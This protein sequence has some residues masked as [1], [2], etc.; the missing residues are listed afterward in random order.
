MDEHERGLITGATAT[1]IADSIERAV[2]QARL[3]PGD[4]LP[5]I[6][7]L[8][9]RLGV[10]PTTV[11]AA[12][13]RL[14]ARGLVTAR[15]RGGTAVA[16]RPPLPVGEPPA[17]LPP[18]VRDLTHG[19]ADPALLSEWQVYRMFDARRGVWATFQYLVRNR[20]LEAGDQVAVDGTVVASGRRR[21]RRA[22]R[23]GRG[24]TAALP[25]PGRRGGALR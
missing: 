18:G 6:R 7:Q 25:A 16:D 4:R 1:E 14:R 22:Q 3:V 19:R 13:G 15:G 10:S 9:I 5:T 20:L 2:R 24:R 8:G 23:A 21:A 11:G 17:L 12:Y